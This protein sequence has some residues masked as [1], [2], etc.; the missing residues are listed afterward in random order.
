MSK[1]TFNHGDHETRRRKAIERI[2][3]EDGECAICRENV[4]FRLHDHHVAGKEFDDTTIILCLNHHA[5]I[6]NGQIDHPPKI[7]NCTDPSEVFAHLV[8]GVIELLWQ[9]IDMLQRVADH[10]LDRARKSSTPVLEGPQ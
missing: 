5:T 7:E 1:R 8:L 4:P 6:T 3:V 10:L 9:I 2:G